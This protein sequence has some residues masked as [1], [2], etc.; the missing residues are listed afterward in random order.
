VKEETANNFSLSVYP[1]PVVSTLYFSGVSDVVVYSANGQFISN[2]TKVKTIDTSNWAAG[3]Y[4]ISNTK[5]QLAKI[6]KE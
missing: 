6:I 2:Y 5:G 1:N 4:F 3:L